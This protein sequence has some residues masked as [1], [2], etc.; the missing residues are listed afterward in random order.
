MQKLLAEVMQQDDM[1]VIDGE[2]YQSV[3]DYYEKP[4]G[5]TRIDVLDTG[6]KF[7]NILISIHE[8]G[9]QL[10]TEMDGITEEEITAFDMAHQDYDGE[11]GDLPDSPYREQHALMTCIELLMC[12]MAGVSW[13]E[14]DATVCRAYYKKFGKLIAGG[15]LNPQ[16]HFAVLRKVL[17]DAGVI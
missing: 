16:I 14:H 1:R 15:S 6:S 4:E 9:E 2:P 7:T 11:P 5:G 10:L 17:R 8:L 13:S 12:T 3:G